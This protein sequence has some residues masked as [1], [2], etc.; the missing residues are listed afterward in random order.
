MSAAAA[1]EEVHDHFSRG[2]LPPLGTDQSLNKETCQQ[3]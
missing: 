2:R 1:E 3:L